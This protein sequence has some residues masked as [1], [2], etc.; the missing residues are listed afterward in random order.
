MNR[1]QAFKI[2]VLN[3]IPI[4]LAYLAVSFSFGILAVQA[5]LTPIQST[6]MSLINVT[7]AGQV[8]ALNIIVAGGTY[9]ELILNQL[10]IN[11]RYALMGFSL[12]QKMEE[13]SPRFHR[14]F[15]AFGLTDEIFAVGSTKFGKISPFYLYGAMAVA[16]PG[17]TIGTFLGAIAGQLLPMFLVSALSIAVYGMFI[18]IILPPAKHNKTLIWVIVGAMA[19]SAAFKYV[20]GL[21]KI[22]SGFVI[23][24]I[25]VVVSA[26][27]ALI[28]PIPVE[29]SPAKEGADAK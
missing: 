4:G 18:A 21:N 16:I 12:S 26:L 25:T 28:K 14:F 15:A 20:P 5:G 27:A 29:S 23:I 1:K 7:S 2:G 10:L 11:L 3:A 24:I 22:S 6:V 17:W 9:F 8:A 13:K 19:L